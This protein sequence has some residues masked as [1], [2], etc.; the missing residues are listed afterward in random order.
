MRVNQRLGNFSCCR[1]LCNYRRASVD[2][3][4]RKH[5]YTTYTTFWAKMAEALLHYIHYVLSQNGV[6]H[7]LSSVPLPPPIFSTRNKN[8]N[9]SIQ[10]KI[11]EN[12]DCFTVICF[13][14]SSLI[15]IDKELNTTIFRLPDFRSFSKTPL[16]R[17]WAKAE[18]YRV[19]VVSRYKA[20]ISLGWDKRAKGWLQH[21]AWL[22]WALNFSI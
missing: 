17:S 19:F 12:C 1:N 15:Y 16:T 8:G 10:I 13:I 14:Y 18:G 20:R 22:S 6:H 4:W 11:Q 5:N 21:F 7:R 9:V 3:K 2:P